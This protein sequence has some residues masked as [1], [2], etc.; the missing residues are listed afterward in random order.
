MQLII[1]SGSPPDFTRLDDPQ[2]LSARAQLRQRLEDLPQ[3]HADRPELERTYNAMT[4]EFDRRARRSWAQA[5]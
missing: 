2:F 4:S 5:D 1:Q 3:G